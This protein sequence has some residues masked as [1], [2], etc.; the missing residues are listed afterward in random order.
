M[1]HFF[2]GLGAV[3][4]LT[5]ILLFVGPEGKAEAAVDPNAYL[6]QHAGQVQMSNP[7]L[8]TDT[9]GI[10]NGGPYYYDTLS[11]P[12]YA[13]PIP[14]DTLVPSWNA[15]TPAGTWVQLKVKVRSLGQWSEWLDM[16]VWASGTASVKRH[17]TYVQP[18]PN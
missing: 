18:D 14:F 1:R 12:V 11:S 8:A 5:L 15:A 4:T 3:I 17:S 7:Q 10:Y 13:T 9:A 16:G 6:G 2:G